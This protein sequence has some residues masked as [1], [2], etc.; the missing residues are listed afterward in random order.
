M[1]S[2]SGAEACSGKAVTEPWCREHKT[3][4]SRFLQSERVGKIP[5]SGRAGCHLAVLSTATAQLAA[6]QRSRLTLR[7][8]R[9]S[10]PGTGS[11]LYLNSCSPTGDLTAPIWKQT[12]SR[13]GNKEKQDAAPEF[14]T[15]CFAHHW[16]IQRLLTRNHKKWATFVQE[17]DRHDSLFS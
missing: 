1:G 2:S 13:E 6:W 8:P 10:W 16:M 3:L 15:P 4:G 9:A 11:C 17:S 5:L 7:G 12:E 14:H